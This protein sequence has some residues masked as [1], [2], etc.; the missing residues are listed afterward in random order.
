MR[1][2]FGGNVAPKEAMIANAPF[3][4]LF[5]TGPGLGLEERARR[6]AADRVRQREVQRRRDV[7]QEG[8]QG[9]DAAEVRR[10]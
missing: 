5:I 7:Q 3:A 1:P 6:R 4:G 2:N 8:V 10:C 9:G